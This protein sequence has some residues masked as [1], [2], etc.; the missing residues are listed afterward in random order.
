LTVA[1]CPGLPGQNLASG[2]RDPDAFKPNY[3]VT[4]RLRSG[5]GFEPLARLHQTEGC[6]L[7]QAPQ[8]WVAR[9]TNPPKFLIANVPLPRGVVQGV[10][11]I[12]GICNI[13]SALVG[14]LGVK[15]CFV[16]QFVDARVIDRLG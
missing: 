4:V 7:L 3:K 8:L 15:Q 2:L 10:L 16:H 1:G 12:T 5:A 11:P 13:P 14:D 6:L 9:R